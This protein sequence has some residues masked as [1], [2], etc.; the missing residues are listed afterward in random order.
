MHIV[1]INTERGQMATPSYGLDP[2]AHRQLFLFPLEAIACSNSLKLTFNASAT[3]GYLPISADLVSCDEI[4][5]SYVD[6]FSALPC[7]PQS[8]F[9]RRKD[10]SRRPFPG[11]PHTEHIS[12]L[13]R[14]R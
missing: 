2:N 5:K 7:G 12:A 6:I 9:P 1:G 13:M 8:A 14:V 4:A 11:D 3:C 10:L